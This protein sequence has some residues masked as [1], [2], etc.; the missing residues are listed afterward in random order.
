M[1]KTNDPPLKAEELC[2][3]VSGVFRCLRRPRLKLQ[4]GLSETVGVQANASKRFELP[5]R[6]LV[7]P[8]CFQISDFCLLLYAL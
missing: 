1:R 2:F 4:L 8:L 5:R 6:S 7:H 3:V